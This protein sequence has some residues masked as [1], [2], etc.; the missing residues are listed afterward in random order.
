MNQGRK[1]IKTTKDSLPKAI[2]KKEVETEAEEKK[3]PIVFVQETEIQTKERKILMKRLDTGKPTREHACIKE[4]V[5]EDAGKLVGAA[6][7]RRR[8]TF[9]PVPLTKKESFSCEKEGHSPEICNA[10]AR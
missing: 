7:I 8:P 10:G 5:H 6:R 2:L 1:Q 9:T 3:K 4:Q